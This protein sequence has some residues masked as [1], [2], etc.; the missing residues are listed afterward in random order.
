[1]FIFFNN[2]LKRKIGVDIDIYNVDKQNV[3]KIQLYI[4]LYINYLYVLMLKSWGRGGGFK[5]N[6]YMYF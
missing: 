6:F 1:M 3:M 4:K 2:L 5:N